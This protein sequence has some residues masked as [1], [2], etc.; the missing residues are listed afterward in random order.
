MKKG[1]TL[2][3]ILVALFIFGVGIVTFFN[4]FPLGLQSL[5]YSRRLNEVYF[6]AQKKMEELKL[7]NIGS[8]PTEGEEKNL[9]WK[10]S[11]KPVKVAEGLEVMLVELNIDFDFQKTRQ[12][13][14]FVTYLA[15]Q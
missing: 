9:T 11:S 1:F 3:E 13:Q 15:I 10:I 14:K 7:Y 8:R 4:L 6:F 12:N 2:V 5:S